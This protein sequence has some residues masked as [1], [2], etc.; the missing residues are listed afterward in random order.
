M[1]SG[2]TVGYCDHT[3]DVR[4]CQFSGILVDVLFSSDTLLTTSKM[5]AWKTQTIVCNYNNRGLSDTNML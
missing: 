5:P 4:Q 2:F 3:V 1:Y